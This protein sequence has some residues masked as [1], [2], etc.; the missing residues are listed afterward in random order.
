[1]TKRSVVVHIHGQRYV[2][3]SDAEES[4]VQA[5]AKFVDDRLSEI[6][7]TS[8]P[9]SPQNLAMLAA[10]NIADDLFKERQRNSAFKNTIREKSKTA[11]AYLN[12]E[13]TKHS[14]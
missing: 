2:I 13:V 5:L 7:T 6:K 1:V 9:V 14:R 3:R 10:L 11:L 8:K 4:Y 12:E